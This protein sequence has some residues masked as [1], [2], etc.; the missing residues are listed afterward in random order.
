LLDAPGVIPARL[1]NQA[2]ALKLA[3]CDDIGEASYDNQLVAAAL[4]DLLNE[5]IYAEPDLLPNQPLKSRYELDS[6]PYTGD[7]YMQLLAAHRYK[8]DIERAA[9]QLV[10]DFRKGFL[11]E[12]PLELPPILS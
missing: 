6:T 11:G 4:V 9:R 2:A 3:I 10:T 8:G 12:I 5:L 1:E 7:E